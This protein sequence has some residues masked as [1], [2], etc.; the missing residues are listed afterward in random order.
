MYNRKKSGPRIELCGTPCLTL[1]Q[2]KLFLEYSCH[3]SGSCV[4]PRAGQEAV[5]VPE[6]V[7]KLCGSWSWSQRYWEKEKSLLPL[8]W[9]RGTCWL[10]PN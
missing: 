7:R 2:S 5:W 10:Q 4:G 1:P 8:L 3:W 6:L 9:I